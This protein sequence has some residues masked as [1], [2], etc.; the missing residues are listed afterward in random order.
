MSTETERA[1]RPNAND[2]VGLQELAGGHPLQTWSEQRP[3]S[4][5]QSYL[6]DASEHDRVEGELSIRRYRAKGEKEQTFKARIKLTEGSSQLSREEITVEI[7][8]SEYWKLKN[9]AS[10]HVTKRRT[11]VTFKTPDMKKERVM[12]VDEFLQHGLVVEIEFDDQLDAEEFD[13]PLWLGKEVTE[14]HSNKKLA[15]ENNLE[16]SVL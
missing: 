15:T 16:D 5:E 7:Q 3:V 9:A 11:K 8:E 6:M 13:P 1:F 4:I 12:D 10:R 2:I 14:T